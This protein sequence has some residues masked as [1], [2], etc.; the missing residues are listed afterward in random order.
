MRTV[1]CSHL[2]L[3]MLLQKPALSPVPFLSLSD[4][5]FPVSCFI[6]GDCRERQDKLRPDTAHAGIFLTEYIE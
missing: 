5:V 4:N 1:L 3:C 6:H 2:A